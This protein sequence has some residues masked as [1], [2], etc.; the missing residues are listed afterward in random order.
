MGPRRQDRWDSGSQ[1][2]GAS[3][4]REQELIRNKMEHQA[5]EIVNVPSLHF[6]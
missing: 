1:N 4:D 6:A 3:G 5:A 2:H